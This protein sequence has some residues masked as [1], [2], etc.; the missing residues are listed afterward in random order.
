MAG[1][2]I[3]LYSTSR[4]WMPCHSYSFDYAPKGQAD[5]HILQTLALSVGHSRLSIPIIPKALGVMVI[6]AGVSWVLGSFMSIVLPQHL[7]S[8]EIF[9]LFLIALELPNAIWLL[10]VGARTPSQVAAPQ[11]FSRVDGR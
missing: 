4:S 7:G 11:P 8:I 1:M 5:R 2:T 9:L 6:A 3:Y 10:V